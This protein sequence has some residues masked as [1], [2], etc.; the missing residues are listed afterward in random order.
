MVTKPLLPVQAVDNFTR[1]CAGYCVATYVLGICDRHNDNIMLK[2]SGH[3]FHIDFGKC[4]GNAQMFGSFKRYGGFMGW[5]Y[6]GFV[7]TRTHSTNVHVH[8]HIT[9]TPAHTNIPYI[10]SYPYSYTPSSLL[11]PHT[12]TNTHPPRRDRAPFVLTPDMAYVINTGDRPMSHFV[13]LCCSA[14]NELRKHTYL[15]LS[16]LSLVCPL[17]DHTHLFLYVATPTS[18]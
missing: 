10:P 13:D 12:L 11:H 1:S 8:Q 6:L 5:H 2:K 4:F 17:C 14:Y 18:F 16:L 3:L 15:F 7:I 9:N